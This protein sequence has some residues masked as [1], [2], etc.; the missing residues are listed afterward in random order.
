MEGNKTDA[1]AARPSID[2]VWLRL[3]APLNDVYLGTDIR[4]RVVA[5][6]KSLASKTERQLAFPAPH[7]LPSRPKQKRLHRHN[8][9]RSGELFVALVRLVCVQRLVGV[10]APTS[11]MLRINSLPGN[12]LGAVISRKTTMVRR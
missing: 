12:Q 2:T 4:A 5:K 1:T 8:S 7:K 6:R 3:Q 11:R 9:A 10:R